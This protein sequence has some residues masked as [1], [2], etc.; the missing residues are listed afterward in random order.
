MYDG[1]MVGVVIPARNEAEHLGEVLSTIPDFVDKVVVVDDG[2]NDGT[3]NLVTIEELVTLTGEGVG[4]AIDAG[5]KRLLELFDQDFVS[6]VIAGDGQMDPAD[7]E[8]LITP[9]IEGKV[10]HS[11]GKRLD[12][13]LI[14]I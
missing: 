4:A 13:S 1:M 2:S 12:L 11:K 3:G 14:H 7:M 6:V 9:V 10:H 8:N 5:H